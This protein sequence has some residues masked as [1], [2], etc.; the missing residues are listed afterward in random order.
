MSLKPSKTIQIEKVPET[1]EVEAW[2]KFN[3]RLNDLA[4]QGYQIMHAT[5][6]YILLRRE[7]AATRREE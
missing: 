6:T 7:Y 1:D 5:D 3:K 4:N 2:V